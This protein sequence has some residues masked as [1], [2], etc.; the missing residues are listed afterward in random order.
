MFQWM[1]VQGK[2]KKMLRFQAAI[3]YQAFKAS[4]ETDLFIPKRRDAQKAK[5]ETVTCVHH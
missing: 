3:S 4:W 5:I 1:E 2:Y